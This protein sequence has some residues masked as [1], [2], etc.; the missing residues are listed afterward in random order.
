MA[1]SPSSLPDKLVA[2]C[3]AI[4]MAALALY[5]AVSLIACI[6]PWLAV[7]VGAVA[8]LAL[9]GWLIVRRMRW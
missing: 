3:F 7:G 4:F 5:G 9:I 1:D 6:W 2:A 8:V